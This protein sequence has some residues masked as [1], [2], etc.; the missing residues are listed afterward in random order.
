MRG[1]KLVEIGG[2]R[3]SDAEAPYVQDDTL[4]KPLRDLVTGK[5]YD[6]KSALLKAYKARGSR[7]VGN[8][9]VNEEPRNEVPDKVTDAVVQD[10]IEKAWSIETDPDKRREKRGQERVELEKFMKH[11]GYNYDVIAKA[12][13]IQ[14]MIRGR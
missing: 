3:P 13:E 7:V 4:E 11:Q 12:H 14:Q 6:S 5:M 8:D 1:G 10:A 2:S 9:W